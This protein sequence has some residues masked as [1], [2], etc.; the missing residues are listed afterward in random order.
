MAPYGA[1]QLDSEIN[2]TQNRMSLIN[3]MYVGFIVNPQLDPTEFSKKL[4]Q[5]FKQYKRYSLVISS[6]NEIAFG[7]I[8]INLEYPNA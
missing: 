3:N 5:I 4:G 2:E 7:D 6:S 1:K 8:K